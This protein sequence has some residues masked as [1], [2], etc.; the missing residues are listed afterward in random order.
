[1]A[2]EFPQCE[3]FG[4][5]TKDIFPALIKP[6]NTTF[7][8]VKDID[9]LPFENETFT[10]INVRSKLVRMT[11]I[12]ICNFIDELA[13]ICKV[14]GYISF[15]ERDFHYDYSDEY[16]NQYVKKGSMYMESNNIPTRRYKK[17]LIYLQLLVDCQRYIAR[18]QLRRTFQ[19]Y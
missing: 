19:R 2:V 12:Q 9:K 3:V 14:Q 4:V 17:M 8:Q 10:L 15:M 18:H 6:A 5:D 1:V 13:R 11:S 16:V 7:K